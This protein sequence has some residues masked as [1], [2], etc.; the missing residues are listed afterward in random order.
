M[1]EQVV[2]CRTTEFLN[3]EYV[4]DEVLTPRCRSRLGA[5]GGHFEH[6]HEYLNHITT[7]FVC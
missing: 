3:V 1:L 5:N 6:Q 2:T 7:I 4:L